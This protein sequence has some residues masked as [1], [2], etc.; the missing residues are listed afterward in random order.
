MLH[1]PM[2][3]SAGVDPL[4]IRQILLQHTFLPLISVQLSHNAD[5][6]FQHAC[7][8]SLTLVLQAVRPYGNNARY[9]VAGQAYKLTNTQL[10]TRT[11][12]LFPVRFEPLLP[13]LLTV[14]NPP[15]GKLTGLFSISSLEV[16]LKKLSMG[17]QTKDAPALDLELYTNMFRRIVTSNKVVL[18]DTLNHPVSQVFVVDFENDSIDH[19]RQ[20]I[21]EFRNFSYPKYFQM[22][23][24][25]VHVF[26]L[27]N[28]NVSSVADVQY[29]QNDIRTHLTLSLTAIPMFEESAD[30]TDQKYVRM[31]KFDNVTIDGEV[32]KLSLQQG[33][34][35]DDEDYLNIPAELDVA[36]RSKIFEFISK[37]LIPHMERKIRTWDDLILSPKKSIAGR[38]FSVSKKLF[39]NSN[40][41]IA[42]THSIE[43]YNA[44]QNYYHR[45]S[46]EQSIRKLADWSLMLK[47]FK[48]AYSTYD[49]I[50]KDYTND[51]AWVYVASTQEMCTVSLLLAQTQPL[52]SDTLPQPPDK[53]TLRKIRHDIIE[54]YI[55]NLSYTFKSRFNVKTY[56]IKSYLVVTELLLNMSIMFNIPWWWS[57][58]IEE[59]YLKTMAEID[60]HL[61][62]LGSGPQV[63]RAILY[64]RLGYA[65]GQFSYV[66]FAHRDL[67]STAFEL[68][69]ETGSSDAEEG[70]YQNVSKIPADKDNAIK[71]LTRFRKQS[72]WYLLSMREWLRLEN[73]RQVKFVL[74][75]VALRY[76]QKSLVSSQ[77]NSSS[78][79]WYD[80]EDL[81]LATIRASVAE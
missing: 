21:V 60:A 53:N 24:V 26:V 34:D 7:Q 22:S 57:D 18:F 17:E 20:L 23:D 29:F 43:S 58:L 71:G 16:V 50:K 74:D 67:L 81:I 40:E 36:L 41:L 2:A 10:I 68:E 13:E 1:N 28:A 19:L 61:A 77:E 49:L 38:F 54:P 78:K 11:Y 51:K 42:Q 65:T 56:A 59:Y 44:V 62:S 52:A 66:P 63:I 55:D 64:E 9:A 14:H 45:S 47:D 39:N 25:L 8:N 79:N 69:A 72:L 75:N 48:Y 3:P 80:R 30:Q 15:D 76:K 33:K 46:P 31:S 73:F 27:Y 6:L 35:E 4:A 12:G 70:H 37:H 5:V 32:Q